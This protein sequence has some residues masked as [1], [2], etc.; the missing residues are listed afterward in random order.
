MRKS[1]EAAAESRRAIV[2]TAAALLRERGLGVGLAEIMAA[3]GMTH[4]GFYR[5]FASKEALVAEALELA[6]DEKAATLAPQPGRPAREALRDYVAL[7]LSQAHIDH[8]E[9]GCPIAALGSEAA[10][11]P[12][13][14]RALAAG[15]EQL[16]ACFAEDLGGDPTEARRQAVAM[17]AA[18]VGAVVIARAAGDSPLRG[19]T[20]DAVR[21]DPAFRALLDD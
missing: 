12:D 6:A 14:A 21:A 8:P 13:S 11:S 9:K 17:L 10:R 4:G 20:L 18:M 5:H 1:R 15:A 3:A 19:E 16:A 7:Y 2:E